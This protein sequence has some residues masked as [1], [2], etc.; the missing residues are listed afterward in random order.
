MRTGTG[1]GTRSLQLLLLVFALFALTA[2]GQS[3][4]AKDTGPPSS[5]EAKSPN[6]SKAAL[7]YKQNCASCH[8]ADLSGR[9]G[10]N[11]QNIGAMLTEAEIKEAVSAGREGMPAFG[12]RLK[13]EEIDA[14]AVWLGSQTGD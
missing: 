8:A 10:P 3:G 4:S 14:L 12:K 13:A 2:C 5:G 9:V 6:E 7:I 11:L 1:T